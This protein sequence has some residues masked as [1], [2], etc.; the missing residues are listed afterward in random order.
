[1]QVNNSFASKQPCANKTEERDI[2]NM[3]NITGGISV[4]PVSAQIAGALYWMVAQ[5]GGGNHIVARPKAIIKVLSKMWN[6]SIA[7]RTLR[8]YFLLLE[9]EGCFKRKVFRIKISRGR[10]IMSPIHFFLTGKFFALI[11]RLRYIFSRGFKKVIKK[12]QK[13]INIEVPRPKVKGISEEYQ[14][15]M[16]EILER[17][18]RHKIKTV[19]VYNGPSSIK[20]IFSKISG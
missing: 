8:K 15:M 1:M 14:Q 7:P 13:H 10:W 5:N 20:E 12:A 19:E 4:P 17:V 18:K 2:R 6:N 3:K 9:K 11:H 16:Q